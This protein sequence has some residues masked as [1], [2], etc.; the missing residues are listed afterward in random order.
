MKSDALLSKKANQRAKSGYANRANFTHA[1][2]R[3]MVKRKSNE[4]G[5][6]TGTACDNFTPEPVAEMQVESDQN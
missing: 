2:R 5:T 3:F 6:N 1:A 4:I